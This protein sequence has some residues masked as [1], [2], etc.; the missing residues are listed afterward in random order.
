MGQAV[1]QGDGVW[2][3]EKAAVWC[4]AGWQPAA[5][6]AASMVPCPCPL[7]C[8][9]ISPVSPA[10]LYRCCTAA[11]PKGQARLCDSWRRHG[12]GSCLL[13]PHRRPAVCAGGDRLVLATGKPPSRRWRAAGAH[14]CGGRPAGALPDC[15]CSSAS[16]RVCPMSAALPTPRSLP[17]PVPSTQTRTHTYAPAPAPAVPGLADLLRLHDGGADQRH[18]A[19]GAG[20]LGVSIDDLPSPVHTAWAGAG[21]A[22]SLATACLHPASLPCQLPCRRGHTWLLPACPPWWLSGACARRQR[23]AW[24]APARHCSPSRLACR[25]RVSSPC[26]FCFL[27]LQRGPVWAV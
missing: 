14:A 26:R 12:R 19:L 13:C 9:A 7:D 17:P 8:A 27:T 21:V 11:E 2:P 15:C 5:A 3:C 20:G 25:S 22:A 4:A 10:A 1:G 6:C 16:R 23:P 24:A 18:D